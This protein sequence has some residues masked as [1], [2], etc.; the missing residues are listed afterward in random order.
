M[1][2]MIMWH[3]R[4]FP[5]YELLQL[6]SIVTF[7]YMVITMIIATNIKNHC[8][9]LLQRYYLQPFLTKVTSSLL[10]GIATKM[11]L[12]QPYFT[13]AID[14]FSSSKDWGVGIYEQVLNVLI[15]C[16]WYGPGKLS[17]QPSTEGHFTPTASMAGSRE[18]LGTDPLIGRPS[19][20]GLCQEPFL[21]GAVALSIAVDDF[22]K[23]CHLR[24]PP[25]ERVRTTYVD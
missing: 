14:Q 18:K 1:Q 12:L 9:V 20:C 10:E 19:C 13:V 5:W 15:A 22:M 6:L 3:K 8:K 7:H 24:G 23:G 16:Q 11:A 21:S 17:I 2:C 4:L 25:I